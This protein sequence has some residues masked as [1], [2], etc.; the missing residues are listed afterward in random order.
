[1]RCPTCGKPQNPQRNQR[2]K[3]EILGLLGEGHSN[4]K[5]AIL[6]R[7]KVQSVKNYIRVLF[8][9]HGVHTRLSLVHFAILNGALPSPAPLS[10]AQ[11]ATL[12]DGTPP[13]V[14]M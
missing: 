14:G 6:L 11:A 8:R 13:P 2:R 10:A 9:E 3:D 4:R 1:M 5:I 7:L 12:L